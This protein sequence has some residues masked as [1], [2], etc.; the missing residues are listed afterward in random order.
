MNPI[1]EE[2]T[3][4]LQQVLDLF[5]VKYDEEDEK[6]VAITS[7]AT[8]VDPEKI[9]SIMRLDLMIYSIQKFDDTMTI[10][11]VHKKGGRF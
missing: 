7:V 5:D 3:Y 8:V 1:F 10:R 4:Q 11:F 6:Y 2:T 9:E